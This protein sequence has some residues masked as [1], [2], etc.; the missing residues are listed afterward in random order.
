M[1]RRAVRAR[2]YDPRKPSGRANRWNSADQQVLYLSEHFGTAVLESPSHAG[3]FGLTS[4]ATWV[5]FRRRRG[6]RASVAQGLGRSRRHTSGT[7]IWFAM[8]SA[9]AERRPPCSLVAGSPL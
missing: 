9:C 3:I 6:R 4:H 8:V 2:T 1:P 5:T 7:R